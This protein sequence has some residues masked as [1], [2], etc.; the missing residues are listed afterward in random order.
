MQ[1]IQ[2]AP[3][4]QLLVSS[5]EEKITTDNPVQFIET[6]LEVSCKSLKSFVDK[7]IMLKKLPKRACPELAEG[8]NR[9]FI[10][11]ASHATKT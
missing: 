1:Y 4:N 11:R 6:L 9:V 2:G 3:R 5:L 10:V 7:P 8:F